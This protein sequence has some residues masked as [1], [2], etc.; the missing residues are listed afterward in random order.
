MNWKKR[1][2]VTIITVIATMGTL[3]ATVGHKHHNHHYHGCHTYQSEHCQ[4]ENDKAESPKTD[5][6]VDE[7]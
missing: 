6:V 7:E 2:I 4:S 5:I 3:Y 1:K